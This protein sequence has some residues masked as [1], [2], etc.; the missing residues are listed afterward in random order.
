MAPKEEVS[1]FVNFARQAFLKAIS[2]LDEVRRVDTILVNKADS[3][4]SKHSE[5]I[6]FNLTTLYHWRIRPLAIHA[7]I[8]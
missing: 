3:I 6:Q 1:T 5:T 8:P 4:A 2:Q 7:S